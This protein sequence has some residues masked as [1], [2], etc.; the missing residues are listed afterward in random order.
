MKPSTNTA[1]A[2][3]NVL[4]QIAGKLH[5]KRVP[6]FDK[7]LMNITI[8]SSIKQSVPIFEAWLKGYDEQVLIN[9]N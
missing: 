4:G 2:Q 8:D 9:S 6:Y 3:A 1:E 5:K 7:E